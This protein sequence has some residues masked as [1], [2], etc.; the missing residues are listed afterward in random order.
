MDRSVAPAD[1]LS[2]RPYDVKKV[3]MAVSVFA[4]DTIAAHVVGTAPPPLVEKGSVIIRVAVEGAA[5][6][7]IPA[8]LVSVANVAL[9]EAIF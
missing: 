7:E 4:F 9:P 1:A 5:V 6:E 2:C 8:K 3:L